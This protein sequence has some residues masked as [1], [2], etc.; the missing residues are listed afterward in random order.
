MQCIPKFGKNYPTGHF[1]LNFVPRDYRTSV[2]LRSGQDRQSRNQKVANILPGGALAE[3]ALVVDHEG[4]PIN[5]GGELQGSCERGK[6]TVCATWIF[7]GYF[8][9]NNHQK[10]HDLA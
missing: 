3:L 9:G 4:A 8:Q 5:A 10:R 6:Y 7:E 2:H 1:V